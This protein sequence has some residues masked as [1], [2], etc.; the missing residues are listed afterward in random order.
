MCVQGN[1]RFLGFHSKFQ[2]ILKNGLD[3]TVS[4]DSEKKIELCIDA[5]RNI[6]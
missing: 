4:R 5:F 1:I 3:Y 6:I 2:D